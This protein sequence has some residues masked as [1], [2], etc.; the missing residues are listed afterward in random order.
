MLINS[1]I[2]FIY[3][4]SFTY[5]MS[6]IL[7]KNPNILESSNITPPLAFFQG[8]KKR[9]ICRGKKIIQCRLQ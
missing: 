5:N 4:T 6:R 2:D 7:W 8:R 1:I 9:K 3:K